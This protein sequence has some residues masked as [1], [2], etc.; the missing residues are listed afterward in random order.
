[1]RNIRLQRCVALS[2]GRA[3]TCAATR[4][5]QKLDESF[6]PKIL[7]LLILAILAT[8]F[9][10]FVVWRYAAVVVAH[11]ICLLLCWCG[12]VWCWWWLRAD[13]APTTI[14]WQQQQPP[15]PRVA[16]RKHVVI[17]NNLQPHS[18]SQS[19]WCRCRAVFC[20]SRWRKCNQRR[21]VC[22][23]DLRVLRILRISP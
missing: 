5:R 4:H 2:H 21:R 14:R 13:A 17:R 23:T 9:L 16:T 1:M 10:A 12:C 11:A 6:L 19:H 7:F 3:L 18:Q 8:F 22:L 20:C 15:P